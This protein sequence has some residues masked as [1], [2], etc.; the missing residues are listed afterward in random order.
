MRIKYGKLYQC[1]DDYGRFMAFMAST[2]NGWKVF[3][4]D[5]VFVVLKKEKQHFVILLP[6]GE[7][8]DLYTKDTRL[9]LAEP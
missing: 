2:N 6:D 3:S 8:A 9:K 4:K 7:T 5:T 1:H